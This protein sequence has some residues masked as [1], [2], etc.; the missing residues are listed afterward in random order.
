MRPGEKQMGRL[1]VSAKGLA[2]HQKGHPWIF[3]DDLEAIQ[4]AEPGAV[5]VLETKKGRFLAQGFYSE[6]SKIAFRLISR[7]PE[8]IDDGFWKTRVGEAHRYRQRVISGTNAYRV[9]YG[10]SD[11]IP[12]LVVDRYGDQLVMQT[13]SR[14]AENILDPVVAALRDLFQ[15]SS[16]LLRN[17]LSVRALE[18]LPREKKVLHGTPPTRAEV[19]EG[20]VRY[21]ADLW[22]GQKTGSYLDQRENRLRAGRLLRGRVL[23]AFCYQGLFALHAARGASSVLAVDSSQEAIRHAQENARLNAFDH[24]RFLKENVFDFL[25]AQGEAGERYDGI[26]LDPPAFAKSRGEV[27][28]A[29]RGYGELNQRAL[30]MLNPGGIL[31]T[32][33]CSYNILEDAFREIIRKCARDSGSELRVIARETQGPDHPILLSFPESQYLKCFFLQKLN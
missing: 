1:T 3:R 27:A 22:S 26:I 7:S 21:G 20:D 15:P 25:K 33:S 17:D 31:V 6:R 24:I 18:G 13:L 2:W 19:F 32:A 9:I 8:K 29:V 5:V 14:G 11:G 28:G 12:S 23:D 4:D 16:I 10:E 30:R